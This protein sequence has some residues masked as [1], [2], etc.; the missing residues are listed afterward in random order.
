MPTYNSC[1]LTA[2]VDRWR[3]ETHTFHLPCGEMTI[4]L[5]DFTIITGLGIEGRPVTGKIDTQNFKDMVEELLG[6]RPPEKEP[7]KKGSKTGGLKT[8][9]LETNFGELPEGADDP[10]A[11]R[12]YAI[13]FCT[14][15]SM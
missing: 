2:L 9:W 11:S 12:L 5:Q 15:F 1:A 4:T 3:P 14:S 13:Y 8:T 6:V 7:G 10:T